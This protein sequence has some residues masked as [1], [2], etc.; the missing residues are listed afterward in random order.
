MGETLADLSEA[1]HAIARQDIQ[2]HV[3]LPSFRDS[4]QLQFVLQGNGMQY[5]A[6][7]APL[8]WEETL[9]DLPE[10]FQV[11]ARAEGARWMFITQQEHPVKRVPMHSIHPCETAKLMSLLM[12]QDPAAKERRALILLI[13]AVASVQSQLSH[14]CNPKILFFAYYRFLRYSGSASQSAAPL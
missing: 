3:F 2:H 9:S 6:D 7:G 13:A 12:A 14:P 1:F 8:S 5:P 11:T 10:A 4:L